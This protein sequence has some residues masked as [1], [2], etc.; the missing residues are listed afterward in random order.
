[1]NK[2]Q[3]NARK[4][5]LAAKNR[6]TTTKEVPFVPTFTKDTH[7]TID[8]DCSEDHYQDLLTNNKDF[9]NV[10]MMFDSFIRDYA[11]AKVL[12]WG[13]TGNSM[14]S[15]VNMTFSDGTSSYEIPVP[16]Q[17]RH[18]K[19]VP[20]YVG[21]FGSSSDESINFPIEDAV[22]IVAYVYISWLQGLEQEG[23]TSGS[24]VYR[25]GMNGIHKLYGHPITALQNDVYN[26]ENAGSIIN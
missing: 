12:L 24:N 25:S 18:L 13:K 26:I 19:E 1:M 10:Y 7:I 8:L 15:W 5:R 9:T 11:P 20:L 14:W 21:A 17:D 2:K 3:Q 6:S 4:K 23:S 16:I 22:K